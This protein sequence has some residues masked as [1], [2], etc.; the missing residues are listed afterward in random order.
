MITLLKAV[1]Q[2]ILIMAILLAVNI[3]LLII[4]ICLYAKVGRLLKGKDAK[5]LEDTIL[6]MDA[7]LKDAKWFRKEMEKYL[8][9]VE[10]RLKQSI[11]GVE[12][13]RF[14][15]FKGTG[16]GGNQSFAIS[17]VNEKGDGVILSSLYSRERVSVFAKPIK[18][19]KSE[20]G[21]TEEEKESL[22]RAIK[23]IKRI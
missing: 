13:I 14:N 9:N 21:L 15:P 5:T 1:P 2:D 4:V 17:F 20:Y 18:S 3:F 6:H 11:Q 16:D 7:E 22:T 23:N 12:T 10:T 19:G 8:Q